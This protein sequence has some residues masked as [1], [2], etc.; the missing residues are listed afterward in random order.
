MRS[1]CGVVRFVTEKNVLINDYSRLDPDY[2]ERVQSL[3]EQEGLKVDTLPLFEEETTRRRPDDLPSA[4]G[5][6]LNYLRV[7]NIVV[8]P[9]FGRPEDQVAVAKMQ[10]VLPDAAVL[11]VPCRSLA[12][13]GGVLNCI[14]WTI[15]GYR[16]EGYCP[17]LFC[18]APSLRSKRKLH[19]FFT[20]SSG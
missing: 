19:H 8:M 13:K 18:A 2:G 9:G 4:V 14:S 11:Q 3:L 7:G 16:P 1:P 20:E 17:P 12:E 10:Q 6:Y 5:L 15:K